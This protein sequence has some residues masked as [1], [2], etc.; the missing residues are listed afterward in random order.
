MTFSPNNYFSSFGFSRQ[1]LPQ[2]I[3]HLHLFL[4]SSVTSATAISSLTAFIN[5]RF[6]FLRFLFPGSSI[7]SIL[8]PI[9]PLSFLRTC[10][11]HLSLAC[12]VSP[13]PNLHSLIYSFLFL[14]IIVTPNENRNIFNYA[15]S[16]SASC[17]SSVPLSPTRTTLLVSLPPRTPSQ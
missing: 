11:N 5:L 15:T 17:F 12:H 13:K 10:P 7:L 8:L 1:G 16:I 9:Y 6:G 14:S 4:S 2:Q 3:F